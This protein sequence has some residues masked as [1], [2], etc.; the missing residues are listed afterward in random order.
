MNKTLAVGAVAALLLIAGSHAAAATL[1]ETF[2]TAPFSSW[3]TR[4]FGANSNATNVYVD[5][6]GTGYAN[7]RGNNPDGLWIAD[8]GGIVDPVT[9][10]FD[11]AFAAS[12]TSLSFDVAS[13]I[14]SE[15]LI[16]FDKDGLTLSDVVVA[17]TYGAMTYPGIYV[18]YGVTSA[19]GIG[20]FTFTGGAGGNVSIDNMSAITAV[21]SGSVPEPQT[22]ALMI[23]GF[24]GLGAVLRQ[25]R[26]A[27]AAA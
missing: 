2:D 11:S 7:F 3:E 10:N 4:W 8:G 16:F 26:L 19:N 14:D 18:N 1:T 22:W 25:R 27:A 21:I 23:M 13:H 20:G 24:A 9:I 15:H 6:Y 17:P 5:V 12:L